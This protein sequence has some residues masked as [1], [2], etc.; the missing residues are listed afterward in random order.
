MGWY[1][2]GATHPDVALRPGVAILRDAGREV[3]FDRHAHGSWELVEEREG[4]KGCLSHSRSEQAQEP[5]K[6]PQA[7]RRIGSTHGRLC[8]WAVL[9]LST[10]HREQLNNEQ[11]GKLS[12]EVS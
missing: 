2:R 8:N 3:I 7:P 5:T 6:G 1:I 12:V 9:D 10:R 11:Q 4:A